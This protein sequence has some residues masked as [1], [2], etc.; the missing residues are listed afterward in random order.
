VKIC[1]VCRLQAPL[2]AVQCV[3]CGH[4]YRTPFAAGP[5][6]VVPPVTPPA[7]QAPT[8]PKWWEYFIPGVSTK[9]QAD[10]LRHRAEVAVYMQQNGLI[11]PDMKRRAVLFGTLIGVILVAWLAWSFYD[12]VQFNR[13]M[14]EQI[15]R[16]MK[17]TRDDFSR[18]P[19][20]PPV[21]SG[22]GY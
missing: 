1:P 6:Q 8:P 20:A 7:P 19:Q 9:Y 2:N 22:S 21:D 10:L 13:R 3:Q 16:D 12:S 14:D 15:E 11:T 5:T 17:Q 4:A 18:F